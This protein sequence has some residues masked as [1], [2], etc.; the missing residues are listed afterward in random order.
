MRWNF[1]K[2]WQIFSW[3]ICIC[4]LIP[5]HICYFVWIHFKRDM[6]RI[7]FLQVFY[8]RKVCALCRHPNVFFFFPTEWQSS[9]DSQMTEKGEKCLTTRQ[10]SHHPNALDLNP[11]TFAILCHLP[12]LPIPSVILRRISKFRILLYFIFFTFASVPSNLISW[13]HIIP[14][15]TPMQLRMYKKQCEPYFSLYLHFL[16]NSLWFGK[17]GQ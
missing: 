15:S 11:E 13:P 7:H 1:K 4:I 5:T 9:I 10:E 2:I 6:H 17:C 16:Q 8:C 12:L 14:P 3:N